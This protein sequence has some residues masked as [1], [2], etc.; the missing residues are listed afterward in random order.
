MCAA[1]SLV[2]IQAADDLPIKHIAAVSQNCLPH[3]LLQQTAF[4]LGSHC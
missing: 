2:K 1:D 3:G 4:G